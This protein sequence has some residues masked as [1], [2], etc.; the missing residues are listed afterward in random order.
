LVRSR[1]GESKTQRSGISPS[2]L[3]DV[4]VPADHDGDG[5]ADLAI[6]RKTTGEWFIHRTTA[7]EKTLLWGAGSFSGLGDTPVPADYDGD[8]AADVAVYRQS[9]GE[10]FIYSL[11]KGTS[12]RYVWGSPMLDAG[13]PYENRISS[14]FPDRRINHS[15]V[16][17]LK[18][19]RSAL[20]SPSKSN[21]V[22][23][24]D[25]TVKPLG[26]VNV[27]PTKVAVPVKRSIVYRLD[28]DL[29]RSSTTWGAFPGGSSRPAH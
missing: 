17:V 15:P 1:A 26:K 11:S 19:P 10:W 25:A 13:A 6:Y 4:P 7:G 12:S 20:P 9:T 24:S 8:G 18:T 22:F 21:S 28:V 14:P 27:S 3:D 2:G 29:L 16:D 23:G 5:R